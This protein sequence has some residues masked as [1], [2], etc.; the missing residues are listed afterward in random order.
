MAWNEVEMQEQRIRFAVLA[1]RGEQTM[2]AL[3]REFDISRQAGYKWLSR[4]REHGVAGVVERSRRPRSSPGRTPDELEQRVVEQRCKRPDWGARKLQV[5]LAREG[6]ELPVITIHRILLRHGLVRTQ[7]RVRPA[8]KRFEREQPN[9]LWQMDFKGMPQVF[10][11]GGLLPLSI[12]DDHSRYLLGLRA[13]QQTAGEPVR[14]ALEEI[15]EAV[16]MPDRMLM[17]HGV[18]WWN[19]QG[20][21]WTRLSVWLMQ[22]GIQLRFSG[23][24]HPQT[25]G[26]VERM[27]G[28]MQRALLRRGWPRR[29]QDWQGWLD[30]FRAE[31]NDERP[32]ESLGM[33]TPASRWRPS[34]RAYPEAEELG[35]PA[36]QLG[37]AGRRERRAASAR[38]TLG[39]QPGIGGPVRGL[40]AERGA[41]FGALLSHDGTRTGPDQ[42]PLSAGSGEPKRLRLARPCAGGNSGLNDGLGMREGAAPFPQTPI[43]RE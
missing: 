34:A 39:S 22:Q 43:P 21:G 42:R 2:A 36:R 20:A 30:A 32:H 3:C 17:D 33:A 35:V 10:E 26:K 8:T 25:Q 16:G 15:F 5:M 23:Y 31:Y 37:V 11:A 40:G 1:E 29:E 27:H 6:V 24:R 41:H 9:E 19:M 13:Q 14:Q 4:Y 18:P 7:D 12:L 28:S 38:R